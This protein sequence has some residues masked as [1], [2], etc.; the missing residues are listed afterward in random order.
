MKRHSMTGP[1][2]YYVSHLNSFP[3]LQEAARHSARSQAPTIKPNTLYKIKSN[4]AHTYIYYLKRVGGC[5]GLV[6]PM[7]DFSHFSV[8]LNC[9]CTCVHLVPTYLSE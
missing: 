8:H 6:L 7:V 2:K 1:D 9:V 5:G 4:T 3:G